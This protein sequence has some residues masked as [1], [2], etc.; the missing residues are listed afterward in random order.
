MSN[1]KKIEQAGLNYD[2]II[3]KEDILPI[4]IY[5]YQI[6]KRNSK[7]D[8]L[9]G[10]VSVALDIGCGTGFHTQELMKKAEKVI[11]TDV[12]FNAVRNAK[13]KVSNRKVDFLVCDASMIPLVNDSV[14]MTLVS[15]VLHHIPEKIPKSLGDISKITKNQILLDEPNKILPWYIIMKL[16]RADPVG[17]ETP[18]AA[19][20]IIEELKKNGFN[21]ISVSYWGFLVQ[22]A[23]GIHLNF[24]VK[25]LEQ[26][27]ENLQN[28]LGKRFYFRWT[29]NAKKSKNGN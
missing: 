28:L 16:S 5:K 13:K 21:E 27:E 22:I 18:L 29:I 26:M 14:D 19:D 9:V 2:K 11:S 23:L 15:G 24:L 17:N 4:R 6:N 25:F 20:T 7:I 12:S 3:F 8:Q 1:Q 10:K